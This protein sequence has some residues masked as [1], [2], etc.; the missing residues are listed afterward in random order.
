MPCYC[1]NGLEE[2][3]RN[4]KGHIDQ[5]VDIRPFSFGLLTWLFLCVICVTILSALF[6]GIRRRAEKGNHHSTCQPETE[7]HG[8][9]GLR[10][11]A[12][13]A[14]KMPSTH[15]LWTSIWVHTL[16]LLLWL[17]TLPQ[18]SVQVRS[19]R[20]QW[21]SLRC[22]RAVAEASNSIILARQKSTHYPD[23]VNKLMWW[24][25]LSMMR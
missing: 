22:W 3:D 6:S 12:L 18:N 10:E 7:L 21:N 25:E 4:S 9:D 16:N 24:L 15:L 5:D 1:C 11:E 8:L 2:R 13:L 23:V 20:R 14:G 17:L 19:I